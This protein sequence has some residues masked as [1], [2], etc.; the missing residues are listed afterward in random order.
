[1]VAL[2][3]ALFL[4]VV[5]CGDD[6]SAGADPGVAEATAATEVQDPFDS[7]VDVV[8][9][10]TA[11]DV[12]ALLDSL[13]DEAY[14]V[15]IDSAGVA[16]DV[17]FV[18]SLDYESAALLVD[19][20]DEGL[21]NDI[22]ALSE[23][24]QDPTAGSPVSTIAPDSMPPSAS[25]GAADLRRIDG[26]AL[27]R[28]GRVLVDIG[29]G[30]LSFLAYARTGDAEAQVFITSVISPSG[31]DVG[32]AIGLEYG[33]LSNF[34]EAA[35]Y[36]PIKEQ[37]GLE[38]G[39]YE[40]AFEATD[41]IVSSGALVRSGSGDGPQALDVVF[42]MATHEQFDRGALEERFRSVGEAV[43][44]RHGIVIGSMTFLDPPAEV[45]ERY[46]VLR[47]V[48]GG[49]GDDLRGLCREMSA[50]IGATRALNFAI[51]DRLDDGDS[52]AIIE[53]SSAG[54]P[55][56]AIL[57]GSDLSCVAGMAARDPDDSGRDLFARAIV[58]WHEAGHHLGLFHTSEG[59]GLSFDLMD[60]TPECRYEERDSNG[61]EFI[62]LFECD[63]LDADNFMFFDGDGTSMT[64]DQAWMVRRHP[65][66]YPAGG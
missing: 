12:F 46:G 18:A 50:S 56:T 36:S 44:G 43:L 59:D 49:T 11:D 6:D 63:G 27:G 58:I 41:N 25:N 48:E 3:V 4:V 9:N 61:D 45:I 17:E 24:G 28:E 62:D 21:Y 35:V 31:V 26:G 2:S 57:A 14:F 65:L 54:L 23:G 29:P 30:D 53:G 38:V 20:L 34:G 1:M 7:A 19:S 42:W 51:V 13:E 10:L 32:D 55:G 5:A 52:D 8:L 16:G 39:E 33:E 47:F 37:V 22:V 40:V 60:D 15:L 66:L 64:A